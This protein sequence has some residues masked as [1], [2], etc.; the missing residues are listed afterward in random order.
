MDKIEM[1]KIIMDEVANLNELFPDRSPFQNI[2]Q[3]IH[4]E[5][6]KYAE[7]HISPKIKQIPWEEIYTI[8]QNK[9]I[10]LYKQV[11]AAI[12]KFNEESIYP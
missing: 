12:W 2:I 10:D 1:D 5:I 9:E 7:M 8:I 3:V 6:A 4:P 11:Q